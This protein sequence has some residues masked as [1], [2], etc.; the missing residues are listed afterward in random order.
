MIECTTTLQ[1]MQ[2]NRG[3]N[4]QKYW[5]EHVAKLVETNQRGKVNVRGI[6]KCKLTETFPTT[7]QTL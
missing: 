2:G 5:Y 4:G 7:N 3:T 1:H 6:N